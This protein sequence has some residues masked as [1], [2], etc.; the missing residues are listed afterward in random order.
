M[1]ITVHADAILA[2]LEGCANES[3][4]RLLAG[5]LNV[6]RSAVRIVSGENSRNKRVS[7]AGVTRAQV[8][9]L[10]SPSGNAC[11]KARD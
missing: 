8:Q 1:E 6:P 10:C 11:R 5:R 3:L 9:A 4:K 7:V 2:P